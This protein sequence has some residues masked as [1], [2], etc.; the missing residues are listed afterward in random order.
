MFEQNFLP[1]S[2]EY[3][4]LPAKQSNQLHQHQKNK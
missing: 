1:F 3:K 2:S 4:V